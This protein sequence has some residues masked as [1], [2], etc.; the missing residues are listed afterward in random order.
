LGFPKGSPP[1]VVA[2]KGWGL[3]LYYNVSQ[4]GLII[5]K[6]EFSKKILVDKKITGR[7]FLSRVFLPPKIV[8]QLFK[9][10]FS[11]SIGNNMLFYKFF[12]VFNP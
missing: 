2:R 1:L 6:Q 11:Q 3:G 4:G 9:A 7:N 10:D 8:Y 5:V 12:F